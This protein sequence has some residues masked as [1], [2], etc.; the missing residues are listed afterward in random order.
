MRIRKVIFGI[1]GLSML[2]GVAIADRLDEA[3]MLNIRTVAS[4]VPANGDLNPYGMERVV[5][6]P[7]KLQADYMLIINFNNSAN[8]QGTGTTIVE[9]AP[10]G[11]VA[12]FAQIDAS[13]LPG[14]CPG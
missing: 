14:A 4:T 8:L 3:K 12:L 10:N 7:G 6:S 2:T 11:T 1:V 5:V 9:V 13:S